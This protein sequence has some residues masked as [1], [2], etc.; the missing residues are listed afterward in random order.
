MSG[1]DASELDP[2]VAQTIRGNVTKQKELETLE[3]LE[4]RP[5]ISCSRPTHP[6]A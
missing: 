2:Y 5:G 1:F 6:R 3:I 4:A